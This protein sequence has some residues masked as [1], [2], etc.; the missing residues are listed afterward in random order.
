MIGEVESALKD[1]DGEEGHEKVEDGM[2]IATEDV[3]AKGHAREEEGREGRGEEMA[4]IIG[5]AEGDH[6]EEDGDG[7]EEL[8]SGD[9]NVWCPMKQCRAEVKKKTKDEVIEGS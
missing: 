5:E 1:E 4:A 3:G 8:I 9:V 2:G 6:V 7:G